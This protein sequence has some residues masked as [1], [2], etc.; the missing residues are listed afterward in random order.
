L[1]LVNCAPIPALAEVGFFYRRGEA[2]V[3]LSIM[4]TSRYCSAT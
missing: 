2:C 4:S 1:K 3:T